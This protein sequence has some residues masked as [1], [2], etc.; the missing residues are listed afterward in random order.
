[1]HPSF[2]RLH[3]NLRRRERRWQRF[4]AS[5]GLLGNYRDSLARAEHVGVSNGTPEGML[6]SSSA[7][8]ERFS[9]VAPVDVGPT[10]L[11]VLGAGPLPILVIIVKPVPSG[12]SGSFTFGCY[13]VLSTWGWGFVERCGPILVYVGYGDFD[14][15]LTARLAITVISYTLSPSASRRGLEV[16]ETP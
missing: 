2:Q 15:L 12:W 3:P 5:T 11:P 4:L 10:A 14:G 6:P 9:L 1:M 13:K 16:R 8:G 7:A